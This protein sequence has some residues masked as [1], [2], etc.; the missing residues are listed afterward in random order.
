MFLFD[1]DKGKVKIVP[2]KLIELYEHNYEAAIV[3]SNNPFDDYGEATDGTSYLIEVDPLT[4]DLGE[5]VGGWCMTGYD[6]C[7]KEFFS[8]ADI[9]TFMGNKAKR[10]AYFLADQRQLAVLCNRLYNEHIRRFISAF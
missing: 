9:A 1:W 4:K 10:F 6:A 2:C 8:E 5:H 3:G 7:F